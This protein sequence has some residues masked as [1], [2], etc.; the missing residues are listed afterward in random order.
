M[1]AGDTSKKA[2]KIVAM[3]VGDANN[4]ARKISCG[5]V[6]DINNIARLFYNPQSY[7]IKVT[8]YG[9]EYLE[10]GYSIKTVDGVGPEIPGVYYTGNTPTAVR[11]M[12]DVVHFRLHFLGIKAGDVITF[13]RKYTRSVGGYYIHTNIVTSGTQLEDYYEALTRTVADETFTFTAT[14]PNTYIWLSCGQPDL[15][16]IQYLITQLWVNDKLVFDLSES[17]SGGEITSVGRIS[18]MSWYD[19]NATVEYDTDTHHQAMIPSQNYVGCDFKITGGTA[20]LK[21]TLQVV[22]SYNGTV[23]TDDDYDFDGGF[24]FLSVSSTGSTST[25]TAS[26]SDVAYEK[27]SSSLYCK[28]RTFVYSIPA[29]TYF[30]RGGSSGETGWG[31]KY[32]NLDLKVL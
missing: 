11:L 7:G 1:Y 28:T 3:Y 19:S 12:D 8:Y 32:Y 26:S 29:G 16:T 24:S 18:N 2:R 30:I 31:F 4:I 6:G 21:V 20:T 22:Y 25:M 17:S 5:Y 13:T 23:S 10:E 15:T 9:T 14:G 27:I